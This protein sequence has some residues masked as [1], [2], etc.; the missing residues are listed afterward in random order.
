MEAGILDV[1]FPHFDFML[2]YFLILFF[3]RVRIDSVIVIPSEKRHLKLSQIQKKDTLGHF[4]RHFFECRLLS[5][6][7]DLQFVNMEKG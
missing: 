5:V 6:Y 7:N 3:E 4:E 2:L 1:G